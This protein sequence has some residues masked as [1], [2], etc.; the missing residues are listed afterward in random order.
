MTNERK[1]L[2]IIR[3]Y[4]IIGG[5]DEIP[6][7]TFKNPDEIIDFIKRGFEIDI[8]VMVSFISKIG[9]RVIKDDDIIKDIYTKIGHDCPVRKFVTELYGII[10]AYENDK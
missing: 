8:S 4:S 1:E 7:M 10:T 9:Y 5:I 3:Y 6:E 2:Y